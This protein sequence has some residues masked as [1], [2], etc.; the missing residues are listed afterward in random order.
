MTVTMIKWKIILFVL[1]EI[2]V[3]SCY[4]LESM[5][6]YVLAVVRAALLQ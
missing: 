4:P 5:P 3:G 2:K 1:V 6:V